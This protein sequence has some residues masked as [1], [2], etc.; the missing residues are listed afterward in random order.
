MD[1]KSKIPSSFNWYPEF[2]ASASFSSL[3]DGPVFGDAHKQPVGRGINHLS[4][5]LSMNFNILTDIEAENI[6]AFLES[7]FYYEPQSYNSAGYFDNKRITPFKYQPF[8]PY[9]SHDF[10]CTSFNHKK[11]DFNNNLVA[12]SFECAHPTVLDSIETNN[13]YHPITDSLLKNNSSISNTQ[14]SIGF[15]SL[16]ANSFNLKQNNHIFASGSYN[17]IKVHADAISSPISVSQS[18]GTTSIN[19]TFLIPNT[20]DRH[21]IFIHNPNECSYYP[22][23]NIR[24]FDFKPS[25]VLDISKSPKYLNSS[26]NEISK[27]YN[28][29]GFNPNLNNLSLEFKGLTDLEAKRI[30]L[31]LESHLGYKKFGFHVSNQYRNPIE[32]A[33][34]RTPHRRNYSHYYCPEWNHTFTYKDNHSINASFI[35]CLDY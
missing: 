26:V 8:Y 6:V 21:S 5:K 34:H 1:I 15:S 17:S 28:K 24:I 3:Y 29:Y 30:L 32:D 2:G 33:V 12:V 14:T 4:M 19:Q 13:N 27:K 7:H 20:T 16:N 31:F 25:R 9:K 10:Y 23:N 35:E 18:V 22:Y 11:N